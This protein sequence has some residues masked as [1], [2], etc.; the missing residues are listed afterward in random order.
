[1]IETTEDKQ[2]NWEWMPETEGEETN[3]VEAGTDNAEQP[4]K[5]VEGTKTE[6]TDI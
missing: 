5:S 4:E 2:M 6:K 3:T 1:M